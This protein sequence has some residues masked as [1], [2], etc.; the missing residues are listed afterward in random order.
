MLIKKKTKKGKK[1]NHLEGSGKIFKKDSLR[2][3]LREQ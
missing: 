1:K 2:E 3:S